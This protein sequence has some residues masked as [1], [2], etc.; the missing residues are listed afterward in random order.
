MLLLS[1]I[2]KRKQTNRSFKLFSERT[3]MSYVTNLGIIYFSMI[4]FRN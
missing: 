2:S 1:N 3:G 4:S